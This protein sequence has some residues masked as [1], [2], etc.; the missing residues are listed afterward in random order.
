MAYALC[1]LYFLPP[2][3]GMFIQPR[4]AL[5]GRVWLF[6]LV[7]LFA[8]PILMLFLPWRNR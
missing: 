7:L 6:N 3:T 5:W 2:I 8:W 4:F 1:L